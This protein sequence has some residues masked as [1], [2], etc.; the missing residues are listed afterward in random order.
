MNDLLF[1]A[2]VFRRRIFQTARG[3]LGQSLSK[4]CEMVKRSTSLYSSTHPAPPNDADGCVFAEG[5]SLRQ[6][7][8]QPQ[9]G[10]AGE[11]SIAALDIVEEGI[12]VAQRRA[13]SGQREVVSVVGL[14]QGSPF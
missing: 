8:R 3:A 9:A 10:K 1:A 13:L 2:K 7:H 12:R 6:S 14:R 5:H 11:V 4:M